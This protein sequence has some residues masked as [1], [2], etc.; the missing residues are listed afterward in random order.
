MH[1]PGQNSSLAQKPVLPATS[2]FMCSDEF[3]VLVLV[4]VFLDVFLRVFSTCANLLW[5]LN[6]AR[7]LIP[8]YV[9]A[10]EPRS[11]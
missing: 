5:E 2:Q 8:D 1:V 6:S 9:S 3:P 11:H 10:A 7:V 4:Y